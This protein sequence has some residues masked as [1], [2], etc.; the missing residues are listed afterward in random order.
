MNSG[1]EHFTLR[2]EAVRIFALLLTMEEQTF[3]SVED[4]A[5]TL[6][7]SDFIHVCIIGYGKNLTPS[8]F[9][10]PR[11]ERIMFRPDLNGFN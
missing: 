3:E 10:I 4:E 7:V 8:S 6:H 11:D 2:D 5:R 1:E 9:L